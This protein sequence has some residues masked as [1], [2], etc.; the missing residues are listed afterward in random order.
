MPRRGQWLRITEH[1]DDPA[2]QRCGEVAETYGKDPIEAVLH[3]PAE[4]VPS[5]IN[6]VAAPRSPLGHVGAT[7]QVLAF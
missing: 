1:F 6:P 7:P 2:A 5:A 4:F 3:C